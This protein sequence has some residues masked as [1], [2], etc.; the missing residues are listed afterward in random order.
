MRTAATLLG[1][2][3]LVLFGLSRVYGAAREP[4]WHSPHHVAIAADGSTAYV[5][6]PTGD[7][8][9]VLALREDSAPV[10]RSVIQVGAHPVEAALSADGSELFVACRHANR[11]DV[12]RCG[13]A[14]DA[15]RVARS[16]P[17]SF[18]PYGLC[19]GV[20]GQRLFVVH[21][22]ADTVAC[23]RAV[24]GECLWETDVGRDPRSM[25]AIDGGRRLVVSDG[26]SRRLTFLDADTGA[27][28]ESREIGRASILRGLCAS[29]DGRWVFVA[30]V[31]SHDEQ[32]TLQMERGWVHSNG[33][34]VVDTQRPGHWVTLLLDRILKGAANPWGLALSV[35]GRRLYVTLAGVHEV[36][37][38]DVAKALELVE[39][40]SPAAVE[41][42][43]RDVEIVQKRGIARFVSSGGIGPRG[44]AVDP[45]TGDLIVANYFS[46]D[47]ALLDGESGDLRAAVP[48][49]PR[50]E[51]T[52]E[53]RG[54][55]LF[56]DARLCFQRWFSCASCHQEDATVDGLNWDLANDGLGNPKNAKSMHD[57]ADTEPAMWSGVRK[58]MDA[59]VA[60]GQRFLG[61]LPDPDNHAAL[62]AFF[63]AQRRAPNPYRSRTDPEQL[64][65]GQA[66]FVRAR[67]HRCHPPP[68][69]TD[70]RM[71]EVIDPAPTDLRATFDTP[72]LRECYRTAPYLHD[73]RAATLRETLTTH[74]PKRRHGR[75][76]RLTEAQLDDLLAFLRSL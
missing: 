23:F 49:G 34:T 21:S 22:V 73:G 31:V 37:I 67:C 46:E 74:D 10:V 11:V 18:E 44:I 26:L 70:L 25:V 53:R 60:A 19:V 50:R 12:V 47:L 66:A 57:I 51:P 65:R 24:D 63:K 1:L 28:L 3:A 32:M 6:D 59:A 52:L 54:E 41:R 17:T 36:A 69:Y 72:S 7:A 42:V 61:F 48:L 68:T 4:I 55:L 40:T 30:H 35:D 15:P 75:V 76:H 38:V 20:D 64:A 39:E 45:R 27:I 8:V 43:A 16:I 9:W 14:N 2:V 62:L 56:N 71:H 13:D 29:A 58:D 5:V 33:F